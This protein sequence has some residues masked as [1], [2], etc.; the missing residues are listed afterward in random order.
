MKIIK[1]FSDIF[2]EKIFILLLGIPYIWNRVNEIYFSDHQA[3]E[4]NSNL[5]NIYFISIVLILFIIEIIYQE[6]ILLFETKF[7][8]N[9]IKVII[10]AGIIFFY[11][12]IVKLIFEKI[13]KHSSIS[14]NFN[15]YF[16]IYLFI[17]SVVLFLIFR[18]KNEKL[19]IIFNFFLMVL[20]ILQVISAIKN[21][22]SDLQLTVKLNTK[23]FTLDSAFTKGQL[24]IK[25]PILL[26]ILDEYESPIEL[27][28]FTKDSTVFEFS[29][30]LNNNGWIVNNKIISQNETTIKS[31][32]SIF[33]FNYNSTD[34]ELTYD[35][36]KNN[37]L[38][39]KFAKQLKNQKNTS[40]I[41]YGIFDIGEAK[42]LSKIYYYEKNEFTQN[43]IKY[44]FANSILQLINYDILKREENTLS[45]NKILLEKIPTELSDSNFSGKF[46]YYHLLMP[47]LPYSYPNSGKHSLFQKENKVNQYT[48][49]FKLTNKYL[50]IKLLD[51]I[52]K[53]KKFRIIITGDHGVRGIS[54]KISPKYTA[55]Y[56]LG[57]EKNKIKKIKNVQDLGSFIY[58]NY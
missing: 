9:L 17:I 35:Y 36:V 14:N 58:S 40:L 53:S 42:A 51:K 1:I 27:Y 30:I 57:F 28:K 44:I 52:V 48:T 18:K 37:L 38:N 8:F 22:Y 34:I 54:N 19:N 32:S 16:S 55:A 43:P 47:H 49:F 31:I 5:I 7:N 46:I 29:N 6:I 39:S 50:K 15:L 10:P 26:I 2:K 12:S 21:R 33:N 3:N 41:N 45:H 25:K 4:P 23:N 20:I 56:F 24:D 11:F 13:I